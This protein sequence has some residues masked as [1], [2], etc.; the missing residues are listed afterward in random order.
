MDFRQLQSFISVVEEGSLCAASK[1]C[2]ISQPALSQ[3]MRSLEE[4]LGEPLL[5][6]K[7]R[8]VEPTTAGELLLAHARALLAQSERLRNEFQARRELETGTVAFG[9]IPTVAPYLL[10][11][12]LGPFRKAH[13]GVVVS[14]HEAR[15]DQLVPMVTA[16]DLEFG[17][18]SDLSPEQRKIG[19]LRLQGLFRETLLLAVHRS[20]PL[21][22]RKS[23][24]GLNDINPDELIHLSGGHCLADQTRKIM[25]LC[26]PDFR[27]QCDQIA[28]AL[29]M[30]S[31][32]MGVTIV[33]EFASREIT[34]PNII[35]RSFAPRAQYRSIHLLKRRSGSLSRSAERMLAVLLQPDSSSEGL[36]FEK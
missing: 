28:T 32:G 36:R 6:R 16:G 20:H 35:F 8:G 33:P 25:K 21:A 12:F 14:V 13:P 34:D 1:R 24:P 5:H 18:L 7:P 22:L 10:P 23:P 2:H 29:A 27:L 19:S 26:A 30:V 4:E 17:I 11:R 3:Q 31:A 9:I 15:T